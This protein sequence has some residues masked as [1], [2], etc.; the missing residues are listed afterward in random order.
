MCCQSSCLGQPDVEEIESTKEVT[1]MDHYIIVQ[2]SDCTRAI[3]DNCIKT[4]SGD[5]ENL[6]IDFSPFANEKEA[7]EMDLIGTL[8]QMEVDKE[9]VNKREDDVMVSSTFTVLLF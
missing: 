9:C 4:D 7:H 3:F 2:N 8:N 1:L 5:P 6:L